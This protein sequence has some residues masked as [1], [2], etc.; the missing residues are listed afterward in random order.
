MAFRQLFYLAAFL[1][2]LAIDIQPTFLFPAS[3][4]GIL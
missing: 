1:F 2:Q 4:V 3:N